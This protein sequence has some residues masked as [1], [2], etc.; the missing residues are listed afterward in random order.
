MR[1]ASTHDHALS[2]AAFANADH[3]MAAV[4][5]LTAAHWL[6]HHSDFHFF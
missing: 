2:F 4:T 1:L 3:D 5:G 6:G